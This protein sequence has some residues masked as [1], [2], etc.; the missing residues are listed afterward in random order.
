MAGIVD[1]I[2]CAGRISGCMER[3]YYGRIRVRG[4]RV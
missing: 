2:I 3:E 1:T 4:G